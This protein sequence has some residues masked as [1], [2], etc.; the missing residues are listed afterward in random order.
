LCA[1]D[2][3]GVTSDAGNPGLDD[4][5][6]DAEKISG[7]CRVHRFSPRSNRDTVHPI[8]RSASLNISAALRVEVPQHAVICVLETCQI[9]ATTRG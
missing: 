8:D 5:I 9:S 3:K 1:L 4:G 6:A 2:E 7:G